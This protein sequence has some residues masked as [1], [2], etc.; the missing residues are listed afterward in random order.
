M[1]T[2]SDSADKALEFQA[3]V[4]DQLVEYIQLLTERMRE[5]SPES[6]QR[7]AAE[8]KARLTGRGDPNWVDLLLWEKSDEDREETEGASS[9]LN[10]PLTIDTV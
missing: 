8:F 6:E 1:W 7:C 4:T 5:L 9:P 2:S 10:K 3:R